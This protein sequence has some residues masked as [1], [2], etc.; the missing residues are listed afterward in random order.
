MPS[1]G[2]LGIKNRID[3]LLNVLKGNSGVTGELV[4]LVT[5]PVMSFQNFQIEQQ[6][7][8]EATIKKFNILNNLIN[9]RNTI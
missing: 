7:A 2:I 5:S 9:I 4:S 6:M 3:V 8:Q 1:L